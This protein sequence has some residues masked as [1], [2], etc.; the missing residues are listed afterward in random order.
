MR[1]MNRFALALLAWTPT[2]ALAAVCSPSLSGLGDVSL[3]W[4]SAASSAPLAFEVTKSRRAECRYEV[5]FSNGG[6]ADY[7]RRA[8]L[9]TASLRYQL[10]KESALTTVLKDFNDGSSSERLSG[11]FPA[12]R[13]LRNSHVYYFQLPGLDGSSRSLPAP[14]DYKNVYQVRVRDDGGR[15]RSTNINVTVRVPKMVELSL[16][17]T[18]GGFD[19][20]D[21]SE[22]VDFGDMT[23]NSSRDF[24]VRVRSNAGYSVSF[25]SQNKSQLRHRT[26]SINSSIPYAVAVNGAAKD[27]TSGN[28]VVVASGTGTT[29]LSG[30]AIP[31]NVKLTNTADRLEGGYL[32]NIT[33]TVTTTE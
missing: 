32:D 18:G 10:Y 25:A 21:N 29:D 11:S 16:V 24:D 12:G 15:E 2:A 31:V 13:R 6:A 26:T 9:G 5:A 28:A 19:P 22:V 8:T 33:V 4:T 27:L 17:R 14:G 7:N 30:R 20:N 3:T 23:A 1:P